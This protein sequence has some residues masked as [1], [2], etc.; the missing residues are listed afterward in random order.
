M[1]R[2]QSSG[3]GPSKNLREQEVPGSSQG[4]KQ[5][6]VVT[7]S[8]KR[9]SSKMGILEMSEWEFPPSRKLRTPA[10]WTHPHDLLKWSNVNDFC[11]DWI[12][13]TQG[14]PNWKTLYKGNT[15]WEANFGSELICNSTANGDVCW[16]YSLWSLNST[17]GNRKTRPRQQT[18]RKSSVNSMLN[19]MNQTL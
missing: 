13:V 2:K 7:S 1:S 11:T 4:S 14:G 9:A 6:R 12:E 3:Q 18:G 16:Q 15:I 17:Q 8:H 19:N 5:P 10:P